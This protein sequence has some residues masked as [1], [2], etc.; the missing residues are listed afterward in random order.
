MPH[1]SL[2]IAY[3]RRAGGYEPSPPLLHG[4]LFGL[5][6]RHWRLTSVVLTRRGALRAAA[7]A[8]LKP[9]MHH[10]LQSK[11]EF[12]TKTFKCGTPCAARCAPLRAA[13]AALSVQPP[14]SGPA[15]W[16]AARRWRPTSVVLTQ[17]G[18]LRPGELKLLMHLFLQSKIEYFFTDFNRGALLMLFL[19]RAA[20]AELSAPQPACC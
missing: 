20:A 9:F 4:P 19:L 11:I 7:D 10:V 5:L 16:F 14:P 18:G 17:L 6:P 8:G 3:S 15:L 12:V 1:V 2:P 13:A